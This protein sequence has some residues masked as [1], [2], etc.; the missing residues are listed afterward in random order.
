VSLCR[1]RT[2][3]RVRIPVRSGGAGIVRARLGRRLRRRGRL[4][5]GGPSCRIAFTRQHQGSDRECEFAAEDFHGGGDGTRAPNGLETKQ[6]EGGSVAAV[7]TAL[8]AQW[9]STVRAAILIG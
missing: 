7:R 2:L 1:A 4:A 6:A 9:A 3:I 5:G 8:V